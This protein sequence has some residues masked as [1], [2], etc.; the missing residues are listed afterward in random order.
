MKKMF[1]FLV[2]IIAIF[3]FSSCGNDKKNNS[4]NLAFFDQ[5]ENPIE[6]VYFTEQETDTLLSLFRDI[7][8]KFGNHGRLHLI[9]DAGRRRDI[10]PDFYCNFINGFDANNFLRDYGHIFYIRDEVGNN[11]SYSSLE[12]NLECKNRTSDGSKSE[13]SMRL[14]FQGH[15][16]PS[17]QELNGTS[18]NAKQDF[19][20][21]IKFTAE[22]KI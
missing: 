17:M 10:Y 19:I 6:Y 12:Y 8:L 7:Q 14:Y 11:N 4:K 15:D 18:R 5:E 3:S 2:V 22:Q 20:D 9:Y 16:Y 21:L 1:F 13:T